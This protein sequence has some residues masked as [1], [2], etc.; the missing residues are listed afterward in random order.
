MTDRDWRI[1]REDHEIYIKGGRVPPP[2]RNWKE[3]EFPSFMADVIKS[4]KYKD[5]TPIQMQ[6]ITIGHERKDLIGLAPTGSGKT[7]AYLIPFILYLN[8][9]PPISPSNQDDGPY[10][11]IL[12]PTRELSMQVYE[13]FVKFA[14]GTKLRATVVVG[15]KSVEDQAF[16]IMT[17]VEVI[18]GTPGRIDDAIKSRYTV[19]NQCSY[20]VID[21]ADK[22][23]D[24]DLEEPLNAILDSI[25][26]TN[27]KSSDE[28]LAEI[29]EKKAKTGQAIYRVTHM[30]SAT[31][32]ALVER[33]ARKYLRNPSYISIG[34][35]GA[36][37]KDIE[38][39]VELI[40]E[41]EKKRRL[42]N[43]LDGAEGPIIIFLNEKKAVEYIGNT[44]EKWGVKFFYLLTFSGK[45]LYTTVARLRIK[46][47]E[48]SSNSKPVRSFLYL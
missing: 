21:E 37:K 10:G 7:A 27:M 32:P 3:A 30:F 44:L 20:V 48:L 42:K 41:G 12:C 9:L 13:Q 31:M 38:Q 19:L 47:N 8:S 17:G 15:G 46:E 28:T 4:M 36:G 23:I 35:P 40:G 6:A 2:I 34:D 16:A 45:L 14:V 25:P 5:P 22:M 33:I 29:Q 24:M 18:I 1:F 39:R 43:I 26:K 11:I